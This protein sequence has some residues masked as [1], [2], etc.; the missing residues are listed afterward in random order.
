MNQ[1]EQYLIFLADNDLF[2]SLA[3]ICFLAA[4]AGLFSKIRESK[5]YWAIVFIC[6]MFMPALHLI[7]TY[8]LNRPPA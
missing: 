6:L 1:L 5:V 4:V 2:G 8:F 7:G 3:I